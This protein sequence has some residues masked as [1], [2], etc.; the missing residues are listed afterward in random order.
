[1]AMKVVSSLLFRGM[2]V[3]PD[4]YFWGQFNRCSYSTAKKVDA[5]AKKPQ[6]IPSSMEEIMNNPKLL[7]SYI[8]YH[9]S[10]WFDPELQQM[11]RS[12]MRM[13]LKPPRQ[14]ISPIEEALKDPKFLVKIK[15][16]IP[17]PEETWNDPQLRKKLISYLVRQVK[18]EN[19]TAKSKRSKI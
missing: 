8:E 18:A 13:G 11:V 10:T 16:R 12:Y 1:M 6:R 17:T 15:P 3:F 2:S 19:A 4:S 14:K 5:L 9:L 7:G